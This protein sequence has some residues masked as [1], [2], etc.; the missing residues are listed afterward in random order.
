[1]RMPARIVKALA[2]L[3]GNFVGTVTLN[4]NAMTRSWAIEITSREQV[5]IT[6]EE[7]LVDLH[8]LLIPHTTHPVGTPVAHREEMKE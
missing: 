1:M 8:D 5:K 7:E 3:P 4:C 6:G 2:L